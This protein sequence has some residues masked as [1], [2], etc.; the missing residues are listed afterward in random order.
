MKIGSIKQKA[1][2]YMVGFVFT[3]IIVV[4]FLL[5]VKLVAEQKAQQLSY[6]GDYSG[7]MIYNF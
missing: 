7:Y 5:K 3:C 4:V 6:Q 1:N 2:P